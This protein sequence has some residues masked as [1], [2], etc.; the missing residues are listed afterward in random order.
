MPPTGMDESS[1]GEKGSELMTDPDL[2]GQPPTKLTIRMNSPESVTGPYFDPM[3][4]A[5]QM[6]TLNHNC[7][8]PSPPP[9]QALTQSTRTSLVEHSL[10]LSSNEMSGSSL[11]SGLLSTTGSSHITPNSTAQISTEKMSRTNLY[12]KGLPDSFN[13][14]KLWNLP[15][16]STQI[17]SVK[18]ATDDDGKCRGYGFIDF[19]SEDA[20]NEALRHIRDTYPAFTI[21]FA[22]ENEKDKTNLYVTNLP[23]SWTTKDSDQLKLVFE[24]FGPIQSAFVMMERSTNRTT[25]R[26][27][28]GYL[29]FANERDALNALDS[30]KN[31]PVILPD[32]GSPIE[33]K[34]ADKH[35]PDTRRRRYP[36]TS[37]LNVSNVNNLIGYPLTLTDGTGSASQDAITAFLTSV[38]AHSH[39]LSSN[40]HNPLAGLQAFPTKNE[41]THRL[42]HGL[43]TQSMHT[44][45]V[46]QH[47]SVVPTNTNCSTAVPTSSS[48][49]V[50]AAAAAAAAAADSQLNALAAALI[51]A[52]TTSGFV[53]NC[54]RPQHIA[55]GNGTIA[56][57]L[58]NG[59]ISGNSMPLFGTAT[60]ISPADASLLDPNGLYRCSIYGNDYFRQSHHQ[61]QQQQQQ[62]LAAAMVALNNG[63]PG[64][65]SVYPSSIPELT[66]YMGYSNL[67]G[68]HA[69]PTATLNGT[70]HGPGLATNGHG[71]G[72]VY[73]A[74]AAA[75]PGMIAA[76]GLLNP[77]AVNQLSVEAL[78]LVGS[79][80][81]SGGA[82]GTGALQPQWVI[83]NQFL[84][85]GTNESVNMTQG[86]LLS[87]AQCMSTPNGAG[88]S[89]AGLDRNCKHVQ[90]FI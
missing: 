40:T 53:N 32:C 4:N 63:V 49:N 67:I 82:G 31:D 18:A 43:G 2:C 51:G 70:G 73:A 38:P 61:Q 76:N 28:L 39:S 77:A 27:R 10:E 1:F 23:K 66:S 13:D 36:V 17:K 58:N 83:P 11:N 80:P 74:A 86:T 3:V 52:G 35:N 8:H 68:Q 6:D 47:S 16:E 48:S 64:P 26:T 30:I 37:L 19:I 24:R 29:R 20:A 60:A 21:K 88:G 15:P 56:P 5:Y 33:A 59:V 72:A 54:L 62:L 79:R 85:N 75:N 90:L 69:S 57:T 44:S 81:G 14:E 65:C 87:N 78:G 25:V 9:A 42:T 22:K 7:H 45:K 84:K 55:C 46:Q 89:T 41:Y 71:V 50:A 12:I 34:F